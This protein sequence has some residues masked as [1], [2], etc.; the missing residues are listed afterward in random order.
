MT[1][2]NILVRVGWALVIVLSAYYLY[3]AVLYRFITPDLLGPSLFNKKLF[4]FG[5]LIAALPVLLGAPLQFY[6]KLR[7]NR[8]EIHRLIGRLYVIGASFAALSAIYLG[9]TIEYEGSR[10]PIVVAGTLW[11]FFTLA[12]WRCAINGR[13]VEHRLFMIRS[14]AFALILIWL[15]II[16]D[17]PGDYIFFYIQDQAIRDTTQEWMSWVIPLL[18][19]EFTISW[20]PMLRSNK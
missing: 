2:R 13:F 10:L 16:G 1:F 18:V 20:L 6:T 4:Y 11:L 17:I 5:H 19:V 15:R 3:R 14:Y 9:A 7:D 12:A 8:P